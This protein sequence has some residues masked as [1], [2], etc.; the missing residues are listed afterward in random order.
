MTNLSGF[1]QI[2]A[3]GVGAVPGNLPAT[4][5]G[6]Q[7]VVDL[8]HIDPPPPPPPV[9]QGVDAAAGVLQGDP[10]AAAQLF[11]EAY[12]EL[13]NAIGGDVGNL[14]NQLAPGLGEATAAAATIVTG[15]IDGNDAAVANG[16]AALV[17]LEGDGLSS[18]GHLLE[19]KVLGG[20]L[21]AGIAST[22]DAA[23]KASQTIAAVTQFVTDFQNG[24]GLSAVQDLGGALHDAG[25]ALHSAGDALHQLGA[26]TGIGALEDVGTAAGS[27][28]GQVGDDLDK[29]GSV[30]DQVS[31]AAGGVA[32]AAEAPQQLLST[33]ATDAAQTAVQLGK[34]AWDG[35]K[36]MANDLGNGDLGAVAT[37][38]G[39]TAEHL[40]SDAYNGV[41]GFVGDAAKWGENFVGGI[42][43]DIGGL[44]GG[45]NGPQSSEFQDSPPSPSTLPPGVYE[46]YGAPDSDGNL[47]PLLYVADDGNTVNTDPSTGLWTEYDQNNDP[48]MTY[49][50]DPS[51]RCWTKTDSAGNEQVYTG[52]DVW[53]PKADAE[54]AP[55]SPVPVDF[56]GLGAPPPPHVPA[57]SYS[58]N[59]FHVVDTVRPSG[60]TVGFGDPAINHS[61]VNASNAAETA[62][63]G[64][65]AA[66]NVVSF[67]SGHPS[68]VVT[69]ALD[70]HLN[71]NAGPSVMN[72][73]MNRTPA[74]G[75]ADTNGSGG[76]PISSPFDH[77]T[78]TT[79]GAFGAV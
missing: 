19:E 51:I 45:S 23:D 49:Q 46:Y 35:V 33:A 21:G 28:L 60:T 17:A 12:H 64:A 18:L 71:G 75:H 72:W 42:M 40:A 13:G 25:G 68:G 10:A 50:W 5:A 34:D 67:G 43:H 65:L 6:G 37:D 24:K 70:G 14:I 9:E 62:H 53:V 11:T 77:G 74:N 61:L 39:A 22:T 52:S 29:L 7:N 48:V 54:P 27:V 26:S 78:S 47:G 55:A 76:G 59:P 73:S 66:G 16:E 3:G 31:A 15:S 32:N 41:K 44:F 30:T 1:N 38:A 36:N 56:G 69:F 57:I 2:A 58:S 63:L 8:P 79:N 4:L 20:E